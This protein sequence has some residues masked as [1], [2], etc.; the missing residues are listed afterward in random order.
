MYVYRGDA[1]PLEN[2]AGT[3]PEHGPAG[4]CGTTEWGPWSECS[5]TCGVGVNTRRRLFVN[6]MG[7][8]KCPSVQI[9]KY[10]LLI[11]KHTSHHDFFTM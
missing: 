1:A 5:V 3:I 2:D 11:P 6:N 9:G 8:K 7:F 10:Y 4:V